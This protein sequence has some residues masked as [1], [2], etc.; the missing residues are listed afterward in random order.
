MSCFF[1]LGRWRV[2]IVT[3][4]FG[5]MKSNKK[6][7][8]KHEVVLPNPITPNSRTNVD[9][10]H[11]LSLAD[12]NESEFPLIIVEDT[13]RPVSL[14]WTIS[15]PSCK[16][17]ATFTTW[18]V[19]VCISS[20]TAPASAALH[21]VSPQ[22]LLCVYFSVPSAPKRRSHSLLDRFAVYVI[23]AVLGVT[24]VFLHQKKKLKFLLFSQSR[25]TCC[26]G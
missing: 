20:C 9:R 5:P 11:S 17:R 1:L 21:A 14:F 22:R 3:V 26:R 18:R 24:V 25:S 10:R 15:N 4:D 6:R 7:R 12:A 23:L 19:L 2:A 13:R 16:S 8:I